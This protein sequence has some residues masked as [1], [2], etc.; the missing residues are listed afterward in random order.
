MRH[1][2]LLV[3]APLMVGAL[4]VTSAHAGEEACTLMAP[5]QE[6]REIARTKFHRIVSYPQWID[7]SFSGC[8]RNWVLFYNWPPRQAPR[9]DTYFEGGEIVRVVSYS[10]GPAPI[11]ENDFR[12]RDGD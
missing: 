10:D 4:L 5:P 6:A 12:Y 2:L 1:S 9:I 7:A 8:Q 3:F 11:V